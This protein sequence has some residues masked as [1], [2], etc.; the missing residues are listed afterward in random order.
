FPDEGEAVVIEGVFSAGGNDERIRF[1]PW[2]VCGAQNV[3]ENAE[4]VGEFGIHV[5]VAFGTGLT[6]AENEMESVVFVANHAGVGLAGAGSVGSAG[7]DGNGF[8]PAA[9]I[10]GAERTEVVETE[11]VGAGDD[12]EETF[13]VH[14]D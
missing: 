7:E 8:G 2:L 1:R 9:R 10:V 3:G 6:V 14:D 11:A 12:M 5:R 13:A 4:K